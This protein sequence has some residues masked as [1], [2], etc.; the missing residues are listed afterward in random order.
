M[1]NS[2]I[3]IDEF[4]NIYNVKLSTVKKRADSIPGLKYQAGEFEILKGT[5]YPGDFHRY[6]MKNNS[7]KK[8]YVLLK[9]ISEYKY[10]DHLILGLYQEQ[11]VDMLKGLLDAGLIK[12]NNMPNNYGANAYDCTTK[13]DKVLKNKTK[14]AIE[15]IA[16]LVAKAAGTF[17][18]TILSMAV[19]KENVDDT[20]KT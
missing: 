12:E 14:E 5:R 8:R 13:G 4:L 9:A 16:L 18:G 7:K 11:F 10:I 20:K 19:P 3:S 1:D 2:K 15:E 6:K 17:V